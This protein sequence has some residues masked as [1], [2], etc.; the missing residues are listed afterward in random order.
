MYCLISTKVTAV[1]SEVFQELSGTKPRAGTLGHLVAEQ[2]VSQYNSDRGSSWTETNMPSW[3]SSVISENSALK[4][5][6][7]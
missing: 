1:G 6:S 2:A 3:S 7:H 5:T 4:Q